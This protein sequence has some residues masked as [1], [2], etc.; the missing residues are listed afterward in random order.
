MSTWSKSYE[1]MPMKKRMKKSMIPHL[2]LAKIMFAYK[3]VEK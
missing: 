1:I 3:Q 2:N